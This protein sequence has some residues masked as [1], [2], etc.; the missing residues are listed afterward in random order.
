MHRSFPSC[1]DAAR[2]SVSAAKHCLGGFIIKSDDYT[3]A[4]HLYTIM[5]TLSLKHAMIANQ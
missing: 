1:S 5:P 3:N 4:Y 2:L